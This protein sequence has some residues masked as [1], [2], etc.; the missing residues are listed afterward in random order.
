MKRTFR[1][2]L[3][4]A[5]IGQ[6]GLIRIPFDVKAAFGAARPKV[7]ATVKSV[8]WRTTVAVYAGKSYIGVRKE[9]FAKSGASVGESVTVTLATDSAPR[10][11]SPPADLVAAMRRSKRARTGWECMSY[12]H[13]REWAEAIRTAKKPE[14]RAR[15][16]ARAIAALEGAA[17]R[18]ATRT[19]R[20]PRSAAG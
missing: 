15:R 19:R 17:R 3:R 4:S 13:R 2:K 18:A 8:T 14:T 10:T 16:I 20:D 6:V 9:I 12:S 5:G 7:V 11:V 1:T